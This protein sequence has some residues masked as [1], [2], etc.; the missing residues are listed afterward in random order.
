MLPATCSALGAPFPGAESAGDLSDRQQEQQQG[1]EMERRLAQRR[2]RRRSVVEDED[3]GGEP[4]TV[5]EPQQQQQQQEKQ[6]QEGRPHSSKR[7]RRQQ[8]GQQ[9]AL[10][11]LEQCGLGLHTVI[12][13]PGQAE[14]I[15]EEEEEVSGAG[16]LSCWGSCH[17]AF[18][19]SA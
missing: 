14:E 19:R 10:L 1:R 12:P 9:G 6:E 11:G 17:H 15:W 8:G 4:S 3:S 7:Q 5:G 2:Q 13:P 18:C 16:R